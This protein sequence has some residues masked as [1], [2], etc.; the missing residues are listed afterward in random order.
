MT[1]RYLPDSVNYPNRVMVGS[2]TYPPEIA[3]NWELVRKL[4]SVIGDFTWTGWDYI[5]EAGVGIPAYRFGEGGFGA[6]YPCQLAY[7][8]D[9]DLTG[10]RRPRQ[11]LYHIPAADA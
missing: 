9:L 2:E 4:P 7:C 8:G 10:F 1:A 6:H 3:R 5:G 11:V